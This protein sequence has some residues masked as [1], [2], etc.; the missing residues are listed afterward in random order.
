M[1]FFKAQHVAVVFFG[2]YQLPG[3]KVHFVALGTG[4]VYPHLVFKLEPHAFR[5]MNRPAVGIV[6]H[7]GGVDEMLSGTGEHDQ[8]GGDA[9]GTVVF[10]GFLRGTAAGLKVAGLDLAQHGFLDAGVG[11]V[12]QPFEGLAVCGVLQ[13]LHIVLAFD[14]DC[15]PAEKID[16]PPHEAAVLLVRTGVDFGHHIGL[17]VAGD[18]LG[19]KDEAFAAQGDGGVQPRGRHFPG[20]VGRGGAVGQKQ[21]H[22]IGVAHLF[23]RRTPIH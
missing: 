23:A 16:K 5:C 12:F 3:V 21:V 7:D 2:Q 15:A 20:R 17:G 9:F 14:A 22:H 18:E 10:F 11:E 4:F 1:R 13:H 8:I 19:G 6:D